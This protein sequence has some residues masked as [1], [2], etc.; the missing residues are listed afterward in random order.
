MK[1]RS[2]TFVPPCNHSNCTCY[3]HHS[4]TPAYKEKQAIHN[5]ADIKLV[6]KTLLVLV[7]AILAVSWMLDRCVPANHRTIKVNGKDCEMVLM[8]DGITSTGG[9]RGHD[10]VFCK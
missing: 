9:V 6:I 3:C 8:S 5:R 10:E 1:S 2:K 7:V 4:E